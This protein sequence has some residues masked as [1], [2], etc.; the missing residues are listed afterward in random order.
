[1]GRSRNSGHSPPGSPERRSTSLTVEKALDILDMVSA[2]TGGGL[3][4]S[5]VSAQMGISRSTAHRYIGTFEKLNLV[6]RD[7]QDRFRLGLKLVELAGAALD[8]MDL[9]SVS[10]PF[11]YEL[12]NRFQET[13]NLVVPSGT[14]VVYVAKV[15]SR[16]S[17]R[18]ASRLGGRMPMSTTSLGKAILAHSPPDQLEQVI[19]AGLPARTPHS[20]VDP[21][22]L[23]EELRLIRER[24]FSID[25]QENVL[26]V[27]CVGAPLFDFSGAIAGAMSIAAPEGRMSRDR[28]LE[29]GPVIW[30]ACLSL[31]RRM[32][33]RA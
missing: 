25:D 9:V 28:C 27:R 3:S 11:M 31:S 16:Q 15:E 6:E 21:A 19:K 1:M 23:C 17:L 8:Q 12:M 13:V 32:G 29:I 4:I 2:S 14:E 24:G 18:L 7:G 5:E 22:I 20:L 10:R 26:G 30:G 33:Y